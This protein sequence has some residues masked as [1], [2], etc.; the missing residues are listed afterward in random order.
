MNS[1]TVDM[2]AMFK[3]KEGIIPLFKLCNILLFKSF[4]HLEVPVTVWRIFNLKHQCNHAQCALHIS[5][6]C[7]E[8]QQL[9]SDFLIALTEIPIWRPF[10]IRSSICWTSGSFSLDS[11]QANSS[12]MKKKLE[13]DHKRIGIVISIS[14]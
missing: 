11:I 10:S 7:C 4:I 12:L 3:A 9:W 14:Y 2:H 13:H 6:S 8:H 5:A 1:Y